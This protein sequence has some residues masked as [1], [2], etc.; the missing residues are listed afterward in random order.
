MA[1]KIPYFLRFA[2]IFAIA[3]TPVPLFAA[4]DLTGAIETV[5]RLRQQKFSGPV[6]QESI[7]RAQLRKHLEGLLR[8]DL[9]SD[10]QT[11]FRAL[12][13]LRLIDRANGAEKAMLDLYE[14]QVIAFYDPKSTTYYSVDEK[15]AHMP[16]V[17]ALDAGVA[18]HELTH[19]LQDQAF[20]AGRA[21]EAMKDDMDGQLAYHA[22]IEGEAMLVMIAAM[23]EM[24]GLP[25]DELLGNENVAAL[26]AA[27]AAG[28]AGVPESV[29]AFFVESAKFPYFAGLEFVIEAY[30][31]GGWE[32]VNKLHLN[33]PKSTEQLLHPELYFDASAT[34]GIPDAPRVGTAAD[35]RLF[36]AELGEFGWKFLLGDD[37]ASGWNG[38]AIRFVRG[39]EITVLIDTS[40]DSVE[41]AQQFVAAYRTFLRKQ[42]IV[43]KF[44]AT[45]KSV[46]VA[47]GPDATAVSLFIAGEKPRR[48][49]N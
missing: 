21:V 23:G 45:G 19:A 35:K 39:D 40:W 16:D 28:N 43:A 26:L 32:G 14:S 37:A 27:G 2:A 48:S 25:L 11:Y 5:E 24:G 42:K 6:R 46:R 8:S 22:V 18:I 41:D 31:R 15:P 33:R 36:D 17:P 34:L 4:V 12:A 13:A 10:P 20:G 7:S 9:P 30:R 1:F 3:L 29:P 44:F 47:Y 49:A 38:D